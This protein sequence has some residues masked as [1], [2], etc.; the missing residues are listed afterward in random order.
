MIKHY[1]QD[2]LSQSDIFDFPRIQ[3]LQSSLKEGEELHIC[4]ERWDEYRED[5][6]PC[7]VIYK[8]RPET[9]AE[10]KERV[11]SEQKAQQVSLERE[12]REFERLAKKFGK[13]L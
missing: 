6:S 13:K 11:K 8:M 4:A 7:I 10:C 9:D 2:I 12:Q 3:E 1:V 5:S